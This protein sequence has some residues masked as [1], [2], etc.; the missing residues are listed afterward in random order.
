MKLKQRLRF[1]LS[2]GDL[3]EENGDL[4][5]RCELD[6]L[7]YETIARLLRGQSAADVEAFEIA[8]KDLERQGHGLTNLVADLR[9]PSGASAPKTWTWDVRPKEDALHD[10]PN[11]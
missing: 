4:L 5:V 6:E 9:C 3:R 10:D 11:D 1:Q 2:F 7:R 8:V